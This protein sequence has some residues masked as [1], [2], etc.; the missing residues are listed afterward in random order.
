MREVGFAKQNPE[1]ENMPVV[2]DN[3]VI[4]ELLLPLSLAYAR[5][6]PARIASIACFPLWHIKYLHK[7]HH[8]LFSG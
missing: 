3:D 8:P 5:Q 6:P 7:K 1:G 4:I 2:Y